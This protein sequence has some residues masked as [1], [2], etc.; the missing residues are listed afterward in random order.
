MGESTVN[1]TSSDKSEIKA[2]IKSAST[3]IHLK[4]FYYLRSCLKT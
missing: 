4:K 3:L 2:L 1:P